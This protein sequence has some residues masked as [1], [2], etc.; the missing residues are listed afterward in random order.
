[1]GVLALPYQRATTDKD[2]AAPRRIPLTRIVR[3]ELRKCFDTRAGFWLLASIAVAAFLTTSAVIV[4][5]PAET[6]TYSAFTL[7]IA[8]PMSVI[9]P[10]I[11]VLSVTAEWTQRSGLTTFTLVPH[12]SRVVLAKAIAV[13]L[14]AP[15]ATMLAFAVGAVG[16]LVGSAATSTRIVWDQAITDALY[17]VL[18]NALLILVGVHASASPPSS[19]PS[20]PSPQERG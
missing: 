18:A 19:G 4:F 15:V 7:A 14:L 8:F 5:A 17:M 13:T 9:L 6:F 12:R 2:R 11:A 10:M 16:N 20:S 1:M 3:V